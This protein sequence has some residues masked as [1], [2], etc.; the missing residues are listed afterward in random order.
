MSKSEG[1][2]P[3]QSSIED[4]FRTIIQAIGEDPQ[5]EGLRETPTRIACMYRELFKGM[6]TDPRSVLT[7]EFEEDYHGLVTL[8]AIPFY[9]MCEHHFLPFYGEAHVGYLANGRVVGVSKLAR[10]VEILARR[11]Q[12]QERFTN[13]IADALSDSLQPAGVAVVVEAH[14]LCLEMRGIQKPGARMVTST[15]RGDLV[16]EPMQRSFLETIRGSHV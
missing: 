5:R 10:V 7:V 14:H 1:S 11:V 9:S 13:Q 8:A 4:A 3:A 6:T 2:F 15:W 12:L 16:A